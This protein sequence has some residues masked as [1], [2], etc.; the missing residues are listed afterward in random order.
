[1]SRFFSSAALVLLL[2]VCGSACSSHNNNELKI[3]VQESDHY[4]SFHAYFPEDK[5]GAV[6]RAVNKYMAP[7]G[8]F[9]SVHDYMDVTTSLPDQTHFAVKASPGIIEITLN[10]KENTPASYEHIKEMCQ[11]IKEALKD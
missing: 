9:A 8:L 1:M 10:R 2:F 11:Q 6:H 3:S 4:Y 7:S 5:T